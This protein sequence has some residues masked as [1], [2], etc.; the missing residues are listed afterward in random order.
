MTARAANVVEFK[1][2]YHE[3]RQYAVEFQKAMSDEN[4]LEIRIDTDALHNLAQSYADDVNRYSAYHHTVMPDR[5]RRGAYL[6]KWLMKYRPLVVFNPG[7]NPDEE[8]R[9]FSLMANEVFAMFCS[10][11][12]LEIDWAT[13][14]TNMI[15]Q[16]ML[17]TLRHRNNSEDTYILFFAQLCNL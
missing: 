3:I 12:L 5:A 15:R 14:V 1:D 11:G 8:V 6:C 7:A 10:S 9:T 4:G 16:I 2:A 17:Y 13:D